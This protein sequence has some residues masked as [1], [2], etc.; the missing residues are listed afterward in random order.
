MS[1]SNAQADL[2]EDIKALVQASDTAALESIEKALEAGHHLVAAKAD[3][4]HGTWLPFL[5]RAG[6]QERKA[7]RLMKLARSGLKSVTV[8]DL[9]IMGALRFISLR[10]QAGVHMD[11]AYADACSGES[12][13]HW[14]ELAMAKMDNMIELFPEEKRA[15]LERHMPDEDVVMTAL[16]MQSAAAA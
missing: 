11:K 4:P 13:I 6:V 14:L 2:A 9:G 16:R 5:E 8:S 15:G 10:E 3:C 12:G 1:L 7:Q